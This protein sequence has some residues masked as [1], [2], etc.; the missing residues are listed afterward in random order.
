[1]NV[2]KKS[3]KQC[4]QKN[5]TFGIYKH[6]NVCEFHFKREFSP[7]KFKKENI[8]NFNVFSSHVLIKYIN[9]I[10]PEYNIRDIDELKSIFILNEKIKKENINVNNNINKEC[11]NC[12]ELKFKIKELKNEVKENYDEIDKLR[13][14]Y[15]LLKIKINNNSN[16]NINDYNKDNYLKYIFEEDAES[17]K[18]KLIKKINKN[19]LKSKICNILKE[20]YLNK[21]IIVKER[22]VKID[23]LRKKMKL[24]I[25]KSKTVNILR[26]FNNDHITFNKVLNKI[27][28]DIKT[29]KFDNKK[30]H[31]S[32]LNSNRYK[33]DFLANL[34]EEKEINR[35]LSN[36]DFMLAVNEFH[37]DKNP[38]RMKHL[39]HIT[40]ELRKNVVIWKSDIIFKHLYTFQN[41]KEYQIS[42]LIENIENIAKIDNSVV[43]NKSNI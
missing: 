4:C 3:K 8:D 33:I 10:F 22:N 23:N 37:N 36:K 38:T 32:I 12:K 7:K 5:C 30:V 25:I 24:N 18:V 21:D 34:Y 35:T 42:Y 16:Y 40:Y 11:L 14:D 2:E 43:S 13:K 9:I 41:I 29:I 19:I 28:G 31:K 17:K 26:I 15:E 27:H 39:C 20:L 1:M 6:T